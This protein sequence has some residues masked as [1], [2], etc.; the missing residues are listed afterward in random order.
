VKPRRAIVVLA[1]VLALMTAGASAG[2][3]RPM[4][5]FILAGQSNCEGNGDG[6]KLPAE[7]ATAGPDLVMWS[8]SDKKWGPLAARPSNPVLAKMY[9]LGATQFGPE[10]SFGHAM[11][12]AYPD[13]RIGIVKVAVGGT[14]VLIWSKDFG[15]PEWTAL[16][17]AAGFPHRQS[18]GLYARLLLPTVAHALATARAEGPAEVSAF[19]WVQAEKDSV[20]LDAARAWAPRVVKL[21]QDLAADAGY[22]PDIPLVVMAPHTHIFERGA[23]THAE[24]ILAGVRKAVDAGGPVTPESLRALCGLDESSV[25]QFQGELMK[26][27]YWVPACYAQIESVG[28]MERGLREMAARHP[29]LAIVESDDLSTIEGLH[30]D[31]DGILELGRRLAAACREKADAGRNSR[32]AETPK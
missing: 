19:V 30:F 29:N 10:I 6:D 12:E 2:A 26:M 8:E 32:Q 4:R 15:S 27:K 18:E 11:R 24:K 7:L 5:V 25:K 9:G 21:H 22:R 31:T 3:A 14:S 28:I 23:S 16:M 1:G 17:D 20:S 13:H